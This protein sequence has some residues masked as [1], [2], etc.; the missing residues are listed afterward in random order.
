MHG[1]G[2]H[3]SCA[4]LNAALPYNKVCKYCVHKL[5]AASACEY[6]YKR[7]LYVVQQQKS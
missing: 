2:N 1:F 6:H 5:Q 7:I 3:I 4:F